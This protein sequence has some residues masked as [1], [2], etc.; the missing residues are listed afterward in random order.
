[1]K[2]KSPAAPRA[3][4]F[5]VLTALLLLIVAFFAFPREPAAAA[6][7]VD[8][9]TDAYTVQAVVFE[10][11]TFHIQETIEVDF[12]TSEHHGIYRYIPVAEGLYDIRI[13][14]AGGD[15]YATEEQSSDAGTYLL[16]QIGDADRTVT[17]KQTY[18]LQYE[19]VSYSDGDSS[20][21]TLSYNMFPT[22]WESPVKSVKSTLILPKDMDW[23]ALKA[24]AGAQGAKSDL[25]KWFSLN[26]DEESRTITLTGNDVPAEIGATISADLPQGYWVGAPDHSGV[27]IPL[28]AVLIAFPLIMLLLWFLCGRDPEIVQTVEFYA[29]DGITPCE[30]GCILDGV[31]DDKDVLAMLMY[32]ADKGYLALEQT[33]G[34]QLTAVFRKDPED[35]EPDF[36]R[37]LFHALFYDG[38]DNRKDRVKLSRLPRRFGYAAMDT[39]DAV[40]KHFKSGEYSLVSRKSKR[41]R[42]LSYILIVLMTT[43]ALL[44]GGYYH[45]DIMDGVGGAVMVSVL[46][47]IG[48]LMLNRALDRGKGDGKWKAARRILIAALLTGIGAGLGTF[49]IGNWMQSAALGGLYLL[50]AAAMIVLS[51]FMRSRTEYAAALLG[52]LLGFRNFIETAEYDRL[53]ALS[54]EDPQYFFHVLP[55]AYVFGM[56]KTWADKFNG[57]ELRQ[58]DWYTSD[59]EPVIR[60]AAVYND[61]MQ[62]CSNR[63][64]SAVRDAAAAK[65]ASYS[66]GGSSGSSF[67]GSSGDFSGGSSGGGFGGGGG[68]AW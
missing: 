28:I 57:I 34:K 41:A 4:S 37:D 67:G 33:G 68:G 27:R 10:D 48:V 45:Y 7:K 5:A 8:Y 19:L 43:G 3:A 56:S 46:L 38:K 22:V 52:K 54:E 53:K 11:H 20:R 62:T 18:L 51:V 61:L 21:D 63:V 25:S 60:N 16:V 15:P 23:S 6:G 12:G 47:L 30:V 17:G 50:S 29:P 65:L 39:K 2:R 40:E 59:K 31:A 64:S 66:S 42:F 9:T 24:Y 44:L 58:P 32:Y 36:S 35:G 13:L 1:M 55:Y 26:V 14:D 49:W